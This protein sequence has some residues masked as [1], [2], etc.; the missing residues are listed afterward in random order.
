MKRNRLVIK[1]RYVFNSIEEINRL[2]KEI[3]RLLSKG[4]SNIDLKVTF[5]RF[6]KLPFSGFQKLPDQ[7]S[8]SFNADIIEF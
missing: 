4:M 7:F 6:S 5:Q 8:R 2:R 1:K 3:S